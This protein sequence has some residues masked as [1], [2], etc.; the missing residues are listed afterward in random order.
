MVPGYRLGLQLRQLFTGL[1]YGR[2][3]KMP[4][5]L[6]RGAWFFL[7]HGVWPVYQ[8]WHRFCFLLDDLF[9][10]GYRRVLVD[11]PVFIIGNFRSGSTFLHRLLAHDRETF[12]SFRTWEIY[13]APAIIQRK[14]FWAAAAVDRKLGAPLMKLL[15][16][17]D[18]RTLGKA[19]LHKMGLW[20][21]EEDEGLMLHIWNTI[22]VW[23]IHPLIDH[24]PPYH[25]FDTEMNEKQKR[26]I[27]DFYEGC[28]KRHLYARGPGKRFLAKNP[29][30]T[31][32]IN[33]LSERF[34]RPQFI[35]LVRHPYD[36]LPS[37]MNWLS[38]AW[39]LFANPEESFPY[40]EFVL[41]M[42]QHWY[43]YPLEVFRRR[44]G[45]CVTVRFADFI[46]GPEKTVR[47]IYRQCRLTLRPDY[48]AALK[49]EAK[50]AKEYQSSNIYCLEDVG[51]SRRQINQR[52]RRIIQAYNLKST[53]RTK[54][55]GIDRL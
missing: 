32:K 52:Y 13:L 40:Q 11:R 39:H 47:R 3:F 48:L 30:L 49:A 25:K 36:N 35:N 2:R 41:E 51:F 16:A 1:F 5:T 12:T 38:S 42:T 4:F 31:P 33:A 26:S 15:R 23:F 21:F 10:P 44:D 18:R 6:K 54:R 9:F 37:V 17:I 34:H 53:A 8:L 7:S 55:S 19:K 43:E 50:N 27:L 29:S 22:L 20:E 14:V 28:I 24:S 46:N 45:A